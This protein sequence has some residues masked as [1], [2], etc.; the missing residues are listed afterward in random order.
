MINVTITDSNG[1]VTT[2]TVPMGDF[3]WLKPW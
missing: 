3:G 1:T 2:V